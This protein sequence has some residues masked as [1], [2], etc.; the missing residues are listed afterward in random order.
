MIKP[1]AAALLLGCGL[2]KLLG[3]HQAPLDKNRSKTHAFIV[4]PLATSHALNLSN[5]Q[6]NRDS[7]R[8]PA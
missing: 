7:C 3:V 2:R 4:K 6:S 5:T 8:Y 1:I